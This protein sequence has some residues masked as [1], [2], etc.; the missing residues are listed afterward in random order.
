MLV[1]AIAVIAVLVASRAHAQRVTGEIQAAGGYDS[2][3]A[4]AADASNR[5]SP[6]GAEVATGEGLL[7]FYGAVEGTAIDDPLLGARFELDGRVFGSG[8]VLFAERLVIGARVPIEDVRLRCSLRGGRFDSTLSD[9]D[10]WSTG[11]RCGAIG[12]LPEQFWLAAD[13]DAGLR[14]FDAGQLDGLFGGGVSAG[15]IHELAAVEIGLDVTR[16]ESEDRDLSRSEIVPWALVRITT[17]H[18]GGSIGYTLVARVFD[19]EVRSGQEHVGRAQIWARPV[20][21]LDVFAALE[22]GYAE[23]RPQALEYERW[24]LIGGV[25]VILEWEPE[26]SG[27]RTSLDEDGTLHFSFELPGATEAAIVGDFNDWD[28]ARGALTRRGSS[29]FEGDFHLTPGRHEYHLIVDGEP[30]R[31]PASR[32]TDDGFGGENA[33]IDVP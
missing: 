4:L 20:P 16:R 29:R 24:S 32:Y 14:A 15:W 2:N 11:A 30:R 21:W 31:P 27:H 10:A 7:A 33:V 3:P 5:R 1:R 26:P 22:L 23:G 28:P 17:E 19:R 25:R 12:I 13:L 9:D 18:V 8:D 6:S